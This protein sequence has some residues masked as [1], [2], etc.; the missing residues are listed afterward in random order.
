MTQDKRERRNKE[1]HVQ[2]YCRGDT[3]LAG[4]PLESAEDQ[5]ARRILEQ[6]TKR[7]DS[8]R[9][10]CGLLWKSD[11]F[12]F[13][14]SYKMAERRLVCLEKKFAKDPALKMKVVDQIKEYLE[15]GY[16]HIA[17]G[18]ELQ[19]SDQRLP[20][21]IVQNPANLG[22]FASCGMQRHV[23]ETYRSTRCC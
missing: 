23:L 12:E 15:R 21:G 7:T 20:L 5:R 8:G 19:H 2:L 22:K 13:P 16:A 6:T 9:F 18:D 11:N 4:L 3:L 14:C 1:P 17:T 10:E